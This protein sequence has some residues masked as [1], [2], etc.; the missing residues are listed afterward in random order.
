[1]YKIVSFRYE[2]VIQ[3]KFAPPITNPFLRPCS[4]CHNAC[5]GTLSKAR[6][7]F[8]NVQYSFFPKEKYIEIIAYSVYILSSVL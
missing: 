8:T 1:M 4:D 7:K 3:K 6:E 5:R 2:S